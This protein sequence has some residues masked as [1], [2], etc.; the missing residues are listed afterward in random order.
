MLTAGLRRKTVQGVVA[1]A[2]SPDHT[3][4]REGSGGR[5]CPA[6]RVDV[7]NANLNGCVVLGGD[8]AV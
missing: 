8:E 6:V 7:D 5:E 2:H 1:L 4:E 3:A